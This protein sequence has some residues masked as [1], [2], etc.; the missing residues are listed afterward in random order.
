MSHTQQECGKCREANTPRED[1]T[2]LSM[3]QQLGHLDLMQTSLLGKNTAL[4]EQSEI[5]E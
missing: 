1:Q 2:G 4:E 3:L 5:A